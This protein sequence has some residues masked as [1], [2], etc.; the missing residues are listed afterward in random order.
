MIARRRSATVLSIAATT[1]A[2]F[3]M[4]APASAAVT[5]ITT[6]T[7]DAAFEDVGGFLQTFY[8]LPNPVSGNTVL[9]PLERAV[10]Q[11][12]AGANKR[13]GL[14]VPTAGSGLPG[15]GDG[16]TSALTNF[17]PVS[18]GSDNNFT[19][20]EAYSF[21]FTRTGTT[22]TF[23]IGS[24][25]DA[26]SWSSTADYFADINAVEFRIRSNAPTVNTPT[27]GLVFSDLLVSDAAT[28]SQSLD[29]FSAHNGD[30]LIKLFGGLVGDF[31]I[32]GKQTLSW[33]GNQPTGARLASQIKLLDLPSVVPEPGSWAML[34][35]GFGLVGAALRRQRRVAAAA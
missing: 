17:A 8:N 25:A 7:S 9:P 30:V 5:L 19:S 21:S 26:T 16:V 6:Q 24:G 27:N 29:T 32:S 18:G 1:V 12:K 22:L 28:A 2:A 10:G 15:I 11:V 14:H 23:S 20:G 34:I 4:A 3:A 31:S 33:T 35:A 13:R